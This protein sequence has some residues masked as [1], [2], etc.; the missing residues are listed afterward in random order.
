MNLLPVYALERWVIKL[1]VNLLRIFSNTSRQS[2][3]DKPLSPP[4]TI[5]SAL[6][7]IAVGRRG[8]SV[9]GASKKAAAKTHPKSFS[10]P[11]VLLTPTGA[12]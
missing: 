9:L 5:A 12:V 3:G 2:F 10:F 11:I 8:M 6:P 4:V 1:V 7:R